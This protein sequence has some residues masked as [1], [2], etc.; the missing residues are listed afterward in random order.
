MLK[1]LPHSTFYYCL[2]ASKSS[3]LHWKFLKN[4]QACFIFEPPKH[5][6]DS[7]HLLNEWV[8][9][10]LGGLLRPAEWQSLEL[11]SSQVIHIFTIHI[12][13]A[14]PW[15]VDWELI[16]DNWLLFFSCSVVFN[17][18]QPHGVQHARLPCPSPSPGA[19][20]NLC[21]FIILS[22][23]KEINPE[24]L[25]EGLMLKLKL[26]YFGHLMRR[27]SSLEKILMLGKNEGGRRRGR[28]RTKMVG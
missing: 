9:R 6:L 8:D 10:W 28:Q 1:F 5:L 14:Y 4:D 23:L 13:S 27:A 3:L 25:L 24:Y 22:I 21:P 12:E 15:A 7:H 26:Q 17:S 20:S 19:C 2:W 18:S 11:Y 16:P